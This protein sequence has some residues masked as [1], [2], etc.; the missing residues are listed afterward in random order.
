MINGKTHGTVTCKKE[1][2]TTIICYIIRYIN[3]NH[4]YTRSQCV[5]SL[6][7]GKCHWDLFGKKP[8]QPPKWTYGEKTVLIIRN[9]SLW[10]SMGKVFLLIILGVQNRYPLIQQ[11]Y[12]FSTQIKIIKDREKME[13]LIS[14]KSTMT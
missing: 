12:L 8:Y 1:S 11:F 6:I 14:L 7:D 3:Y 2:D 4:H 9:D 13:T 10:I 5:I